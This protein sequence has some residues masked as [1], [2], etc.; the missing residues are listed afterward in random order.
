M[1]KYGILLP[2]WRKQIPLGKTR[3]SYHHASLFLR[4]ILRVVISG[5]LD[6]QAILAIHCRALGILEIKPWGLKF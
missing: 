3:L 4:A 1:R 6:I 2:K 5:Y